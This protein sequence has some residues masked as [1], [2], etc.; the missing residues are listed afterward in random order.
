MASSLRRKLVLQRPEP[1]HDD[2]GSSSLTIVPNDEVSD[3]TGDE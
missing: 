3:T 2:D 1:S